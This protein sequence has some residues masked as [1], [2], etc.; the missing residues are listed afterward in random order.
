MSINVADLLTM[1]EEYI[2]HQHRQRFPDIDT[3]LN[4]P[5][6]DLAINPFKAA[7][8]PLIELLNGMERMS[9]LDNAPQMTEEELDAI[10]NGNYFTPRKTGSK[11]RGE[12]VVSLS[13]PADAV[14]LVV[15]AGV[16]FSTDGGLKFATTI[17][18]EISRLELYSMYNTSTFLYEVPLIVE[19]QGVGSQYNV[20]EGAISIIDNPFSPYIVS[21]TNKVAAT[22]GADKET[23]SA[24]AERI[25][26][27]YI[28]RQLG[29]EPGYASF[30]H[31]SFPEVRDVLV[32][33]KDHPLM[34]RDVGTMTINGHTFT[35]SIGGK[36]DI[37][38]RGSKSGV[39][40]ETLTSRSNRLPL[41][42][43]ANIASVAIVNER[44]SAQLQYSTSVLESG[45][46]VA[47][48]PAVHAAV[49]QWI[50]GDT[51]AATFLVDT[52]STEKK[53]TVAQSTVRPLKPPFINIISLV[54]Q[55]QAVTYD[56]SLL[57]MYEVS[58]ADTLFAGTTLEKATFALLAPTVNNGDVVLATYSYNQT[59]SGLHDLLLTSGNRVITTDVMARE[60]TPAYFHI[61]LQVKLK[62]GHSADQIKEGAIRSAISGLFYNAKIGSRIEKS[63]LVSELYINSAVSAFLDFIELPF[64]TFYRA[65]SATE[66]YQA[67][68]S[69]GSSV[70]LGAI[71]YPVM[72]IC[73]VRFV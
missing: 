49:T 53:F 20:V 60:A 2:L 14:S 45:L 43:N 63:D 24:Y 19:A 38:T 62:S 22:G 6:R 27:F 39:Q 57:G 72:Q 61:E 10:G 35:G 23:N 4:S 34:T 69:S 26:K 51:L 3:S 9:N 47:T 37:Y 56:L 7:L 17:R 5:I 48:V 67:G 33:G 8:T 29:T 44:T 31:E 58:Y 1:I 21:A 52:V 59:L 15:P 73:I 32:I 11:A 50:D 65:A 40:T 12:V 55:T 36:V 64:V 66:P 13:A 46:V 18:R 16:V 30:V 68:R 54:N 70:Q 41:G 71:E 42:V 25:K 28:S